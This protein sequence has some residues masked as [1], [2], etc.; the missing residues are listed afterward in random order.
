M[1]C[2]DARGAGGIDTTTTT[3]PPPL[4]PPGG[5]RHCRDGIPARPH[6]RQGFVSISWTNCKLLVLSC[7][8][9]LI[10]S[11]CGQFGSELLSLAQSL[12]QRL[13]VANLSWVRQSWPSFQMLVQ[14]SLFV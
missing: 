4:P 10:H 8:S 11:V 14:V 3:H 13:L 9:W 7:H 12:S 5:Q 6:H 1:S 2:H